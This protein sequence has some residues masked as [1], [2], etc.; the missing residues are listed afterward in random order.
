MASSFKQRCHDYENAYDF[1]IIGRIPVIVKLDGKS[2]TKIT[3]D[4]DKPFC[5]KTCVLFNKTMYSLVKQ[6][7]GIV[8]AYQYS[9]KIIFILRNDK[10]QNTELWFGNKIQQISSYVSSLATYEFMNNLWQMDN[11]PSLNGVIAFTCHVFG[12]S[13]ISEAANYLIYKQFRSLQNAIDQSIYS[14]FEE[15]YGA[16]ETASLLNGKDTK[17]REQLLEN[18]GIDFNKLP[19]IFRHGTASYLIPQIININSGQVT[20]HEW[21]IDNNLPLFAK[22]REFLMTILSSGTDIFRPGKTVNYGI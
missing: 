10:K 16:D 5:L 21:T 7:E 22:N 1:N 11:P 13:D 9:D 3:N 18:A 20:R 6:I 19:V 15:R 12:I 2:F 17:D 4:V 14:L 8:F